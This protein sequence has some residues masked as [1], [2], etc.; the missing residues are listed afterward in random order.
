[1]II[2]WSSSQSEDASPVGYNLPCISTQPNSVPHVSSGCL[3]GSPDPQS[4]WRDFLQSSPSPQ[5]IWWRLFANLT[6]VRLASSNI[7][8]SPLDNLSAPSVISSG[9]HLLSAY[10]SWMVL[11]TH[12]E[13]MGG[14]RMRPLGNCARAAANA[15]TTSSV[16]NCFIFWNKMLTFSFIFRSSRLVAV[17]I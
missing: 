8:S 15:A 13:G 6:R 4:I 12:C 9:Y 5:F 2:T 10:L 16:L 3:Q 1:M 11:C 14:S 17:A 7:L